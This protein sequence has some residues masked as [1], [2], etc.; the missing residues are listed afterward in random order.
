[1]KLNFIKYL[2]SE[3]SCAKKQQQRLSDNFVVVVVV[4]IVVPMQREPNAIKSLMFERS[5]LGKYVV[6]V[7]PHSRFE[8]RIQLYWIISR[9]NQYESLFTI[10][11]TSKSCFCSVRFYLLVPYS[12]DL[13]FAFKPSKLSHLLKASSLIANSEHHITYLY[14][15]S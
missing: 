13:V 15:L 11:I 14:I 10:G 8:S 4:V 2:W 5:F 12:V 3:I 6:A 9:S 7:S 1:M